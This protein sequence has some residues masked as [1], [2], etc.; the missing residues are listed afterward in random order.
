MEVIQEPQTPGRRERKKAA[1]RK[2]IADAALRLFLERGYDDVGI[3]EIADAADVSTATLFKH[4][5]SK[6]ALVFDLDADREASLLD[7]VHQRPEDQSILAALRDYMLA[8]ANI[9]QDAEMAQFLN[10]IR[11]TQALSDYAHRMWMRHEGALTQAIAEASGAP[12]DDPTC[13]A[14]AHFALET[15]ALARASTD[16]TTAVKSAFALLE[17]GWNTTRPAT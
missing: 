2:A 8:R 6:E 1:T 7:A 12:H 13:A 3:R 15:A 16:P 5:P 9:T 14:L 10:L 11:S 17:H 4:F